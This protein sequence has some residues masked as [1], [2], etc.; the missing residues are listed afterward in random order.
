MIKTFNV[1][2]T[3]A[4]IEKYKKSINIHKRH[5]KIVNKILNIQPP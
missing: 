3:N 1:K 5:M 2:K 4:P